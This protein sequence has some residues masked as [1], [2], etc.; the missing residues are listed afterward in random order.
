ME[1]FLK[2]FEQRTGPMVHTCCTASGL[3]TVGIVDLV[4]QGHGTLAWGFIALIVLPL[5][6]VVPYRALK[7]TG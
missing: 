4:A 2:S 1:R 7:A 6:V 3:P 5:F